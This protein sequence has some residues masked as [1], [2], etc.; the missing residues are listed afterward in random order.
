[1]ETTSKLKAAIYLCCE[2]VALNLLL[3]FHRQ[4]VLIRFLPLS[5]HP[6]LNS[7]FKLFLYNP[8]MFSSCE[9]TNDDIFG[10]VIQGCRSN[11][12]FTLLFEQTMLSM[13]PSA[14]LLLL[15]PP[16]IVKLLRSRRKTFPTPLRSLKIVSITLNVRK[17]S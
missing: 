8:N 14:V 7:L 17:M 5:C 11:F 12:D 2:L 1:M 10:P 3:S 13:P 9:P 15:A 16:R 6:N 4:A